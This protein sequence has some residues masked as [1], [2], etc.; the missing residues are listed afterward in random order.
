MPGAVGRLCAFL[1]LSMAAASPSRA[2]D[3]ND[4]YRG[5][6]ISLLVN[7]TAGGPTDTEARLLARH[8]PNHI[9]GE[10]AIAVRNMAGAAG[11]IGANWLG[12]V[13]LKDGLTLGYLTGMAAAATQGVAS[14][15]I[16]PMKMIFLAGVESVSVTYA[17]TDTQGGLRAPEDLM[18]KSGFWLGGLT[19]DSAKDLN[20][21]AELDL[22]GLSYKYISGYPGAAEAR[23]ALEQNE[24]QLTSES[25][26]T[27]RSSIEP[28]LVNTGKVIPL[29]YDTSAK[30]RE[31]G[32]PDLAGVKAMPFQT[33]YRKVKG[34]PPDNDLWRM[35]NL[36]MELSTSLLRTIQ[37][38]P[39]SPRDAVELLRAAVAA[40]PNDP[41]YRADAIHTLTY[42]PRFAIG[43]AAEKAYHD[44]VNPD[45]AIR[46]FIQD[47]TAKGY[48][49]V[50]K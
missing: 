6:Q 27:F 33:Y 20:L 16:D 29:W 49:L 39:D 5:K 32:D 47:Y 10:P 44:S 25:L 14:L 26:P 23:M 7:Y 4:F 31:S 43:A 19:P 3:P 46:Q 12:Q 34:P 42:A 35:N 45:P 21:R 50:G 18:A 22:L 41:D 48:A 8:L 38:P 1:A 15:K 40:L 37:M 11:M 17:R 28:A 36:L 9:S 13:A 24:V 2:A 30:Y